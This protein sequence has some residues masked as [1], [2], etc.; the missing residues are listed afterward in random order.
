MGKVESQE[1]QIIWQVTWENQH[2]ILF[3][4]KG[5]AKI[6]QINMIWFMWNGTNQWPNRWGAECPPET[7]DR[8]IFADVSGK[9]GQGKKVKRREDGWKLKRK[10]GKL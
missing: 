8:E 7:S 4:Q 1:I 6:F 3:S 2:T 5:L 9:K 10:E